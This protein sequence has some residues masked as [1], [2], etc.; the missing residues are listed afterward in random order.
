MSSSSGIADAVLGSQRTA[1]EAYAQD[2]VDGISVASRTYKRTTPDGH[3]VEGR[4]LEPWIG[5][6]DFP[7]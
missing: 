7:R 5:H 4:L 3:L 1:I 6:R 2:W